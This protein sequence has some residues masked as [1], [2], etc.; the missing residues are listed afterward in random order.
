MRKRTI[1]WLVLLAAGLPMSVAA[2]GHTPEEYMAIIEGAQASPGEN[3]LASLTIEELVERFGV[4]G[5]SVAVIQDFQ[6]HWAK[7]YGIADVETGTPVG[8]E[9][10]FQAASISKPVAAMGVLKAVQDGM[11]LHQGG[12]H[13]PG[14]KER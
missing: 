4:P 2:Q 11:I 1:S 5:V 12:A 14:P 7:G 10:V 8:P 9:T 3:E 13:R 6:I